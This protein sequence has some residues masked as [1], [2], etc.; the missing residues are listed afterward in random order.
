MFRG[1]GIHW[2]LT[3]LLLRFFRISIGFLLLLLYLTERFWKEKASGLPRVSPTRLMTPI[4][5]PERKILRRSG[6]RSCRP[7]SQLFLNLKWVRQWRNSI[8]GA[9]RSLNCFATLT[10]SL[11]RQWVMQRWCYCFCEILVGPRANCKSIRHFSFPNTSLCP[12]CVSG[13]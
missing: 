11:W 4:K 1:H 10:A 2:S 8:P 6:S 9:W 3:Y 12:P 7:R 5:T 13:H